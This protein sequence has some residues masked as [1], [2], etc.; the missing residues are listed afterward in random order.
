MKRNSWISLF[1]FIA[2][3]LFVE[4]FA[5][6]WTMES[7]KTW[8]PTLVKPTWTPPAQ[9]FGPVWTI[10][11]FMIAIS[12][13][14]IYNAESSWNRT[15]ALSLYGVQLALNF[16]WSFFFFSLQ[17]P[18]FGVIN[19]TLLCLFIILTILNSWNVRTLASLLLIPYLIWVLYATALNAS[20]WLLN[21]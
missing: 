16:T 10:L 20:I 2:L 3:C 17:N 1:V 9:V 15:V 5:S 18:L 7:V 11:Y 19:I 6:Y 14:L 21:K 12:G 8:Y 13:W 4:L